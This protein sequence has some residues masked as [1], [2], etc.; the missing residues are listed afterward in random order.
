[1]LRIGFGKAD[2]TPEPGLPMVG[3]PGSPIGTGVRW[4]LTCRVVLADDGVQ[5]IAIVALD[6]IALA[7]T[8]V[9]RL[10]SRLAIGGGLPP[11]QIMVACSHTHRAPYTAPMGIDGAEAIP[12]A[13]AASV[14]TF[15]DRVFAQTTRA[16][17]EAAAALEPATLDI[18]RTAVPGWA[19]NRRPIYAG[20]EVGTHGWAW[21]DDF[22][23]M[24]GSPDENVWVLVARREDGTVIGGLAGFACH[25]TAMAHDPVYSADY[26]GVLVETLEARHGGVFAFLLG[27]AG[28]TST[29]DPTSRDEESGFGE[30]HT[31]AMGAALA[32]AVDEALARGERV[33]G[34]PIH[35][36]VD[37]VD[38]PQRQPT[39]EQVELARWYLRE[40]PPDLDELAFTRRL[41]GHDYTFRDGKQTGN[42]R[43]AGELLKMWEWQQG[44]DAQ[45]VERLELQV[46]RLGDVAIVAL[47]V[48][49]FTE[50]GERIKAASPFRHTCI[51]TLANGWHGYVPTLEA[52]SRGGYEP[53]FAFPSR[54]AEDA[55]E[56]LVEAAIEAL[57]EFAP[58]RPT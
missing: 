15:L 40:A 25:P 7:A 23:R 5:R 29:P 19:F 26:P 34:T 45:L 9:A 49:V 18:G 11:G 24:E 54:L 10:R 28:D 39:P 31:Q 16:M 41:Y 51:A 37:L 35:S 50:L 52:F 38:I 32:D 53:R 20:G 55:G 4:P 17:E 56:Q 27:A 30:A 44:P 22:E 42:A 12:G 58:S 14:A 6:L 57:E 43:H 33:D 21:L 48:E 8:D 3:M 47:P 1:M 2:I 36:A 46:I 13:D